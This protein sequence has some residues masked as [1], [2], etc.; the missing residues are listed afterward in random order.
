MTPLHPT[1]RLSAVAAVLASCLLSATIACRHKVEVEPVEVKPIHMTVDINIKVDRQLE[2][3]FDFEEDDQSSGGEELDDRKTKGANDVAVP[4][5]KAKQKVE[6][7][8][9]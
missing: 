7:E 1:R 2:E 5:D 9:E 8:D 6:A 3:F 4:D